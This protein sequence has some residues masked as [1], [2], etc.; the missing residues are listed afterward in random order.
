MKIKRLFMLFI[1]I[2]AAVMIFVPGAHA[3]SSE[4]V[5]L[6]DVTGEVNAAMTSYISQEIASAEDAGVPL[7][8]VLDTY[9]GQILEAD[10]IKKEILEATVP[11]DCYITRNALSA[12]TLIA[13][14][15]R[16]I[17]M[18]PSAVIGAAETIP[19]DEKTLS[20]WVG[21]LQSAAEARGRDTK[22]I[23]AMADKDI[24]IE[25]V[26]EAGSL[27][28]LGAE[29][30]KELGI[31]DDTATGEADALKKL[32]Y[33]DYSITHHE[34]SFPV[35]AAQFLTSTAVAS[36][37]FIAAIV[38]M[39]IEIFT[40]GFGIFGA[41]SI[42]CFS[43][44]FGGNLLAGFAEWW[45]IALFIL[46]IIFLVIEAVV[47]GFGVFGILGIAGL[48]AGLLFASRDIT[49][50]ITIIGIA[51]A[52]SAVILPLLYMMFK[53]L[54]LLRRVFLGDNMLPE[55]GYV[56][57]DKIPS[58]KGKTGIALTVLRPA[59]T[60]RIE[61]SSYS[62][63]SSGM[64]IPEGTRIVVLEHTPGRIVV[65]EAS[66]EALTADTDK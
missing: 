61:G 60:A 4:K 34:M 39:G 41:L 31:S 13:I 46:G 19:N 16:H 32:G 40:P 27:L 24:S 15:C 21:I 14:S 25:G 52:A 9:G 5:I 48:V 59:G 33:A 55:E 37:L 62:V 8:L 36:I 28:T 64:F 42:I 11:V 45:S 51:I 7:V 10:S 49:T 54:G 2:A 26:T 57:H 29:K 17:V 63:V 30:A 22:V 12:G 44:Y 47:P 58:L 65:E 66:E 23:A 6:A 56:S 38:C 53:R 50:F 3:Q 43:L 18:A 1:A 35:K 20:T